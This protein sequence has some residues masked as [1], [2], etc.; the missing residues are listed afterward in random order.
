MLSVV[1]PAY[2]EAACLNELLERISRVVAAAVSEYEIVVVDDGSTDETLTVAEAAAERLPVRVVQHP[3][4]RGYGRALGSGFE[5]ALQRGDI[6]VT[7]DAD[8]SHGPE[9]ILSMIERLNEGNDLVIASRFVTGGREVGVPPFRRLLSRAAAL[10]GRVVFRVPGVRDYTSGYR[11]YRSTLLA[12]LVQPAEGPGLPRETG[13]AAGLELLLGAAALR[14]S[15]AEVPLVLRY[16][17][18]RSESGLRLRD[19]LPRY[20]SL[21]F[22]HALKLSPS[23]TA[24]DAERC[25]TRD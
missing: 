6:V 16:D 14:A 3:R 5:A 18:K 22:R 24:T 19:A 25:Q 13:F 23:R 2:N 15:I 12:R 10:V 17:R 1:L 20:F 4:N 9:L 8:D 11:A 7:L 21:L